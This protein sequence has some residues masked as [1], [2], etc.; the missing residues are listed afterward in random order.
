MFVSGHTCSHRTP[1]GS[2]CAG[3]PV[4]KTN[5][6]LTEGCGRL[7]FIGCSLRPHYDSGTHRWLKFPSNVDVDLFKIIF[8]NGG[9]LP[10]DRALASDPESSCTTIVG[11][12]SRLKKCR[13]LQGSCNPWILLM[14]K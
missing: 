12:G 1:E 4:F 5:Q 6:N 9:T 14:K 13:K 11:P 7:P 2:F 3:V 8:K 10:E